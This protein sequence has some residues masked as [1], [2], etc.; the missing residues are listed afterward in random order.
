MKGTNTYSGD[1]TVAGG[2]LN[3]SAVSAVSP[4]SAY[5]LQ[6]ACS[7][8]CI[9]SSCYLLLS[10][11]GTANVRQLWIDGVQQPNGVYGSIGNSLGATGVA[12]IVP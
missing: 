2:V 3:I 8:G 5:R 1:T 12:G 7:P 9:S 11:A 6:S 10:Y 4:N